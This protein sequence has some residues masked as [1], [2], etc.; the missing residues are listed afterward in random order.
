MKTPRTRI[1]LL[2]AG[3]ATAAALAGL[4]MSTAAVAADPPVQPV[5]VRAMAHFD[6][7]RANLRSDDRNRLLAEVSRMEGVTW[8][9]VTAIGHTDSV[10]P[11]SYN[12]GLSERRAQAIREYLVAQ[13]LDP[14]MIEID[15]RADTAPVA[16]ND[17]REG[18][19][20]NRRT[21]VEFRGVRAATP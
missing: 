11:V 10:G 13:G 21:E 14:A 2:T 4:T 12:E 6:F 20:Q 5:T 9:T 3:L 8:Q 19:A 18:R 16:P 7:D 17:T 1:R 15:G